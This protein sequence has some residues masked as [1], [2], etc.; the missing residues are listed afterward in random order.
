MNDLILVNGLV[1]E[2]LS[3]MYLWR[4]YVMSDCSLLRWLVIDGFILVNV[5]TFVTR[6]DVKKGARLG[7]VTDLVS[8]EKQ[9]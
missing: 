9:P 1:V 7:N 2:S 8:V 6:L 5:L 4:N 3:V